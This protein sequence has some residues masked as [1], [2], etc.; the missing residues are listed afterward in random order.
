MKNCRV[1]I[2]GGAG[3]IGSTTARALLDENEVFIV[4]NFR[5]NSLQHQKKN[6]PRLDNIRVFEADIL[7]SEALKRIFAEVRPT[8]VVHAAAVAGIETVVKK[9]VST[10]EINA[11]GTL[12]VLK[13]ALEI[14]DLQRV[15]TFSTSEI[16]GPQAYNSN[17]RSLSVIG[18]V[19]E[20]RWS[21]AVSKLVGEHMALA[22][23]AQYGM[24][25]TVLRPFNIYGPGQVGEGAL[26]IFIQRALQGQDIAIHG[27][28]NQ[29][30]AWCY[31]TDMVDAVIKALSHPGAQGKAFN[32][33]NPRT[34]VTVTNLAAT[35]VRILGSSSKLFHVPKDYADIELRIPD[36]DW[37]A[38]EIGFEAKVDLE[39]GI[40]RT[41]DFYRGVLG[42]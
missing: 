38:K 39:E 23:F 3:F 19:G 26:S 11:M 9:P 25:T 20:P 15:V 4:D 31:V 21:Y 5:R 29:I 1:L 40:A 10:I 7:D 32:I 22:F 8:H 16:F 18:V 12:N 42:L 24:P 41:A 35:V 17:E 2:T 33:G 14:Q 30:R 28:G 34:A 13:A 37:A 6:D 27:H 36:P